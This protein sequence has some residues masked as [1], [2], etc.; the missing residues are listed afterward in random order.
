MNYEQALKTLRHARTG[1]PLKQKKLCNA[2][3]LTR[4]DAPVREDRP[5]EEIYLELFGQNIL[6]WKDNGHIQLSSVGCKTRTTQDRFNRFMPRGFRI[7]QHRPFWFIKTPT[8]TRPFRDGMELTSDGYDSTISSALNALNA[9]EL[10]QQVKDYA[11]AY[12]R[13]LLLGRISITSNCLECRRI[14]LE[15]MPAARIGENGQVHLLEHVRNGRMQAS[16]IFGALSRMHH[17][18]RCYTE[19]LPPGVHTRLTRRDLC[20]VIDL[21]WTEGQKLWRPTHSTKALIE[22]TELLLVRENLPRLNIRP[23]DY[24][25]NLRALVEDFLL[26]AF[27]FEWMLD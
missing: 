15:H 14:E 10:W 20:E 22:K 17:L 2:T 13:Q 25:K 18:G 8:G 6:C 24:K 4:C 3:W 11:A 5:K 27:G 1:A 16:V 23:R 26:E 9:E 19:N 12:V 7:W 21:S